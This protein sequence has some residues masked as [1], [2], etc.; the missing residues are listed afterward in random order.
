MVRNTFGNKMILEE[1]LV[2]C[3]ISMNNKN[4]TLP[5]T[6]IKPFN[7]DKITQFLLWMSFIRNKSEG[8][9]VQ[10]DMVTVFK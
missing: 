3:T 7:K 2:D 6:W 1:K 5:F 9:M 10:G 8:L 4:Y